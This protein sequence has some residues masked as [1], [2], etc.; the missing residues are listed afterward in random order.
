LLSGNLRSRVFWLALPA[1]GEQF[2]NFSVGMFDTWLAGAAPPIE[3]A[4]GLTT[5]AVGIAAYMS[6]LGTLLFA[7]VGSG[8]KALV[9]RHVGSGQRAEA[10]RVLNVGLALAGV[11]GILIC[12]SFYSLVPVYAAVQ[13]K[14]GPAGDVIVEY[15]R[16]E[17]FAH[18]FFSFCLAGSAAMRGA[19]DTRSPLMLLGCVNVI[20]MLVSPA[21]VFGWGPLPECGLRGVVFGTLIARICGGLL[22]LAALARGVSGLQL[23]LR[24]WVPHRETF[25]RIVAVGIPAAT[26]GVLMWLAQSTFLSIVSRLD[27]GGSSANLAAH[28]IGIQVE[29]LSYLAATAWGEAAGSMMGQCLGAGNVPRARAACHEAAWQGTLLAIPASCFY[30][31]GAPY[32]YAFMS[33]EPAVQEV[34]IPAMRLL[35]VY[36]APLVLLV[37]HLYAIRGA[38]DTR[39]PLLLNLVCVTCVRLPIACLLTM[40]FSLGLSGAWLGMICDV[41]VRWLV[42]RV[43]FRR[44]AWSR[45]KV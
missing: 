42:I 1:L 14:T 25:R 22:F 8:V 26:D 44:E 4:P 5:S 9:A 13:N 39:T 11:Q 40:V 16:I 36:Q 33:N 19:G 41:T 32:I 29:A 27:A 34:G 2:L 38:G 15:L 7:L 30:F 18:L 37:I 10:N 23:R 43:V 17:A 20:N 3:G 35:A 45:V 31:F 12:V 21:L 6:W 28:T 24:L